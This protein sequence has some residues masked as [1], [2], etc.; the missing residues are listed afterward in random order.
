MLLGFL[1]DLWSGRKVR[2]IIKIILFHTLE[3]PTFGRGASPHT[4]TSD[5]IP[6]DIP[7]TPAEDY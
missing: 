4:G 2:S 1:P 5:E 6:E 3:A 7:T